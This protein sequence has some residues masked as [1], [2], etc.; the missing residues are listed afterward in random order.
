VRTIA[1][2]LAIYCRT[3]AAR[4]VEYE[5]REEGAVHVKGEGGEGR[6]VFHV[7]HADLMTAPLR[8]VE[9]IYANFGMAISPEHRAAME[10]D[11]AGGTS[12]PTRRRAHPGRG[13]SPW[14]SSASRGRMS[15]RRM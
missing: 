7:R 15:R 9:R 1:L 14:I 3:L 4:V 10:A 12:Q 11:L 2:A 8:M 13:A 5:Q 6:R